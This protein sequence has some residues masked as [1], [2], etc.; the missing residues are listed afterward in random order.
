[1]APCARMLL[2]GLNSAIAATV[3]RGHASTRAREQAGSDTQAG[4]GVPEGAGA[5]RV[6]LVRASFWRICGRA[7]TRTV[8]GRA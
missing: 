8:M 3:C 7:A 4:G 6:V 2:A 1:M 5:V